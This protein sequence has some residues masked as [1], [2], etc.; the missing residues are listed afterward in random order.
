MAEPQ[1]PGGAEIDEDESTLVNRM[2]EGPG[3]K[4]PAPEDI[5]ALNEIAERLYTKLKSLAAKLQWPGA[6]ASLHPTSLV[7]EAYLK[8]RK[9]R[10]LALK[11]PEEI[12][13][14]FAKAMR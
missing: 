9:S 4:A 8:L 7:N 14:S 5:R 2:D 6:N 10:G 13:A 12:F 1:K 11:P 3:G